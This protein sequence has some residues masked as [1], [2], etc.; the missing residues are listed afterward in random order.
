[1]DETV[2]EVSSA[3]TFMHAHPLT[4]GDPALVERAVSVNEQAAD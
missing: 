2:A 4:S 1:M 3:V